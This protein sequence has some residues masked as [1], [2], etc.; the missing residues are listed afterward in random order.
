[1]NIISSFTTDRLSGGELV[2]NIDITGLED[3]PLKLSNGWSLCN[4]NVILVTL[5]D[6]LESFSSL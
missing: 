6:S 2:M 4:Y 5:I 1:M 3:S